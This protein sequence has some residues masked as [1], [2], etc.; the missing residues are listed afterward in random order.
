MSDPATKER[1]RCL[2]KAVGDELLAAIA[3]FEVFTPSAGDAGLLERVN[4]EP[5]NDWEIPGAFNVISEALQLTVIATLSRIWDKT[6]GTARI[7]EIAA[8]LRKRRDLA[9]DQRLLKQWLTDVAAVEG[10]EELKALRGYRNVGLAH[11][12]DPN[13]PD[14]RIRSG[15]RRLVNGDEARVLKETTSLVTRLNDLIGVEGPPNF[16]AYREAWRCRAETFWRA[17]AP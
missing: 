11:R 6:N 4:N 2:A 9:N 1:L 7:E 5:G 12:Q 10:S 8:Q 15:V 16:N 17:V 14:D 3:N 13:R